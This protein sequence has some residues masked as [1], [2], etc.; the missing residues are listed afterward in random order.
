MEIGDKMRVA[1][2]NPDKP[3]SEDPTV[4]ERLG[5]V[6][7]VFSLNL[8]EGRNFPVWLRFKTLDSRGS[9]TQLF[10]WEELE[11]VEQR[12]WWSSKRKRRAEERHA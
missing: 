1:R 7:E 12:R 11:A 6:G 5:Q 10:G 2:H 4:R 3:G 8:E 9:D